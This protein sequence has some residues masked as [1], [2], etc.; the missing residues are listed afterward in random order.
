MLVALDDSGWDLLVHSGF[1]NS[2][3]LTTI[4]VAYNQLT[5]ASLDNVEHLVLTKAITRISFAWNLYGP[6]MLPFFSSSFTLFESN[7]I[8][9][10]FT[11]AGI[12]RVRKAASERTKSSRR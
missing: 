11:Q 3:S 2:S 1:E 6:A 12:Q 7:F 10:R 8:L 5:D 4:D 9:G